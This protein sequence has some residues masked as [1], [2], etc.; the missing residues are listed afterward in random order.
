MKNLSFLLLITTF[1]VSLNAMD[2]LEDAKVIRIFHDP[3]NNILYTEYNYNGHVVEI[4][5]EIDSKYYYQIIETE[6]E[7]LLPHSKII[8]IMKEETERCEERLLRFNA[9]LVYHKKGSKSL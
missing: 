1:V 9:Q 6:D 7:I 2:G 3:Q 4:K 5:K 8:Q